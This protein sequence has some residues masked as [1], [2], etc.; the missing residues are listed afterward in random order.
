MVFTRRPILDAAREKT[1][2]V[3]HSPFGEWLFRA[4]MGETDYRIGE[5]ALIEEIDNM[6]LAR[7][8]G[9]FMHSI[10]V[11]NIESNRKLLFV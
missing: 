1:K 8:I 4:S 10:L 6:L 11:A 3:T 7:W 2:F 9:A 5:T